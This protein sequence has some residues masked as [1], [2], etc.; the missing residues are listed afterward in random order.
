MSK[1]KIVVDEAM[2]PEELEIAYNVTTALNDLY[3]YKVRK[4]RV[5]TYFLKTITNVL[6]LHCKILVDIDS[7]LTKKGKK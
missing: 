7:Q 5:N 6:E 2:N 3:A 4:K 1:N